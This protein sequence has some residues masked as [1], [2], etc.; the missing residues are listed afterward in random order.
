MGSLKFSDITDEAP[1]TDGVSW[2]G[3]P[4]MWLWTHCKRLWPYGIPDNLRIWSEALFR[5]GADMHLIQSQVD[6]SEYRCQYTREAL[7]THSRSDNCQ[8]TFGGGLAWPQSF[9]NVNTNAS[10]ATLQDHLLTWRPWQFHDEPK[11]LL[12]FAVFPM[13]WFICGGLPLYQHWPPH[14]PCIFKILR[15]YFTVEVYGSPET[16]LMLGVNRATDTVATKA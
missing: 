16:H 15:F 1:C 13:H 8:T 12:L 9:R 6:S 11:V 7:M 2:V 10:R 4:S 14:I 5:P 3:G